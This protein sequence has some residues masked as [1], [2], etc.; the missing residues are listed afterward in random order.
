M[1]NNQKSVRKNFAHPLVHLVKNLK[2][3]EKNINIGEKIWKS[4]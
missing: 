3:D 1:K 2:N 4:G